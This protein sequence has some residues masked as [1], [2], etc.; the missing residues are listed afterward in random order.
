MSE[1]KTLL[2]LSE[3]NLIDLGIST[4]EVIASIERLFHERSRSRAWSA[5][6]AVIQPSDGR[7][8]MAAL[9]SADEPPLLAV[10]TLILNPSN[11]DQGL[12]Q[13]NGLVTLLDSRTGQP[14]GIMDGNWITEVRTAGLS[15]VAA[16]RMARPEAS[17]VAFIG[18]GVQARSHLRAFAAM[19]PLEEVRVFGRGRA[20]IDS[21]CHLAKD[22]GLSASVCD[23]GQ[24]AVDEADLIVSSVTYSAELKPFLDA[25][26]LKPGSFSAITDLTAPWVWAKLGAFDRIVIDDLEQ[27]SAL[28]NKLAPPEV[29]SGDI[30]G[31][32]LGGIKGRES[33]NDRTAFIFRG[34]AMGDLAL[35]GLAYQKACARSTGTVIQA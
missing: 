11:P 14:V 16:K 28:P 35:A 17:V 10:K 9:A 27:E 22:F 20:N 13:I 25:T 32:V 12:P 2:Y 7:Y 4:E 23:T 26:R 29:V 3:S 8:M 34:H 6:K 18:C 33:V 5:P 19:F 30:S 15:A 31:L 21:L 24:N 1:T